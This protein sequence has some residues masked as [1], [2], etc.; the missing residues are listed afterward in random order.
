MRGRDG[1]FSR[2]IFFEI[3][4]VLQVW[5]GSHA[6]FVHTA[7]EPYLLHLQVL[8]AFRYLEQGMQNLLFVVPEMEK[9][10]IKIVIKIIQ[11]CFEVI[12]GIW[13]YGNFN[14]VNT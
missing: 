12:L 9:N 5:F 8:H 6:I 7:L 10:K 14:Y 1:Y 13:L 4:N 3:S 11:N 2:N